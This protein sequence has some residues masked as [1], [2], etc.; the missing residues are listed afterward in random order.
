LAL[1]T[2]SI[3]SA[4]EPA[5]LRV[6]QSDTSRV[7]VE[8]EIAGY[9]RRT[10]RV[11]NTTYSVLSVAGL[12]RT[13][14]PGKPQLPI[15]GALVAIPPGAQPTLRI[16]QDQSRT[17]SLPNPPLPVPTVRMDY[18]PRL[19]L[20]R[21]RGLDYA[22][23][24][25]AYS[26]N[27]LYPTDAAKIVSVGDWRSQH[28]VKIEFHPLQYNAATRQLV[29]HQRL[30]VE[31]ALT[32]PRGQTATA[33]GGSRN[34]GAFEAVFQKA[35]VNYASARNWRT[36]RAPAPRARTA[37]PSLSGDWFKIGVNADGIYKV[38]CGQLADAKGSAP[39]IIPTTLQ[40]FKQV[41]TTPVELAINVVG[42]W[43]LSCTANDYVE[44][45]GQAPNAKYTNTN[46]YWLR[47]G[48][49]TGKR[50]QQRDGTP[51]MGTPATVFTKTV[52]L[53]QNLLYRAYIPMLENTDHWYWTLFYATNPAI[54]STVQADYA[55]SIDNLTTES[56]SASLQIDMQG[57]TTGN[58]RTIISVNGTQIDD[59]TWSGPSERLATIMFNQSL[60]TPG[61][62]TIR[63]NE[64]TANSGMVAYLNYFN[65][66]YRG[67]FSTTT[68]IL[69]F[70]QTISDTWQYQINGFSAS[71]IET[72]DITDPLNVAQVIS[73]TVSGGSP[74]TLQ[75][76]DASPTPRE[77]IVTA[78]QKN[79]TS[80]VFDTAS[81]L[82]SATNGAD[83]IV[84][85][86]P[87]LLSDV[88]PLATLRNSQFARP[89]QVV[90]VQDVYDEFSDGLVD[91][92]AIRDFLQYAYNFW[93]SPAP[94][95]VLLVGAGNFD[96]KGYCLTPCNPGT[97]SE[98][99]TP[100]NSTFI[101]PYLRMV[102]PYIGETVS[103]N[104][105]VAFNGDNNLPN[106]YIGRLPAD[107]PAD[108]SALV[109]KIVAYENP[110]A[111]QW[112]STTAFVADNA[113][114]QYGNLDPGGNFFYFSDEIASNPTY[115]PT[116]LI[117]DRIYYNPCTDTVS[118]P[119]CALP[120]P[121]YSTATA[122]HNAIISAINSGRLFVNYIGHGAIS[123]WA[124][125]NLFANSD[126]SGLTNGN[127][128]PIMLELTCNTGYFIYPDPQAQSLAKLNVNLSGKGAVASWA[129][130]G[131][132]LVTGHDLLEKGFFDAVMNQGTRQLGPAIMAGKVFLFAS[133]ENLDLIDTTLLL[134]DP[135]T[136]AAI[137]FQIYFPFIQK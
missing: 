101:P 112:R 134:G 85:A 40:L 38:T 15:K 4:Q 126:F 24:A 86:H 84:I 68:D 66:S 63:V 29:F 100:A 130:S 123:L 113:F 71:S 76:S 33:L 62:N 23:N 48:V 79:P 97:W 26:A 87:T 5:Q 128:T 67:T 20:P 109:S 36:P 107:T 37:L 9:D 1:G 56:F 137:Q 61:M 28:F 125:E 14:E 99:N 27:Q 124:S 110:P 18:D 25:A 77:Y 22:A 93:Q 131:Q 88:Q 92:Q 19:T 50:M 102:D 13:S 41:Y 108:A 136:R 30:R 114:D 64:P 105:F 96:P 58:H 118:Y 111:G 120:Y 54:P 43:E 31:I 69:R 53:E 21:A 73:G 81:S 34:E 70:Q 90:D 57:Y 103:D 119:W 46:I 49:E 104:Q 65:I 42:G 45:F 135:A 127:R 106:T 94:S 51:G 72:F 35:F 122:A 47:Y 10:T 16:V 82:R 89:V 83:Y 12:G 132:G 98:I 17:D 117:A 52:H 74:F 7:V 59:T 121:S 133:G 129:A 60:L 91:A 39:N 3:A 75:F 116:S 55:L 44:F 8:L 32:Y 6:L 95:Y 2:F 80:V 11:G 78:Q 115:Y